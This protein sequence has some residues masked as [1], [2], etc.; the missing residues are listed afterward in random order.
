MIYPGEQ[1]TVRAESEDY[2][3]PEDEMVGHCLVENKAPGR[4]KP[5]FRHQRRKGY[6][7]EN[8][9]ESRE[10]PVERQRT[11]HFCG[12]IHCGVHF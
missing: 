11:F 10:Q 3:L 6:I 7:A 1:G 8:D 2:I 5:C 4:I 9:Y 12:K